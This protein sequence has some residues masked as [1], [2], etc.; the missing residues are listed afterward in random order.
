LDILATPYR[1]I[2]G[3]GRSTAA[4]TLRRRKVEIIRKSGY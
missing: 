1:M 3:P 2:Y 4:V